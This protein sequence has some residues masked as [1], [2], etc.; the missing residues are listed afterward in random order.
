MNR[1]VSKVKEKIGVGSIGV[2]DDEH[3]FLLYEKFDKMGK[4]IDIL[5]VGAKGYLFFSFL[6][7][8]LKKT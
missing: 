3:L 7:F 6:F 1:I 4:F 2:E 5:R 8:C